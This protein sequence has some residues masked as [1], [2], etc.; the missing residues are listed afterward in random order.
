MRPSRLLAL[1]AVAALL[2]GGA[3][4]FMGKGKAPPPAAGG[5]GPVPVFVATAEKAAVPNRVR[6]VGTVK[7]SAV[8]AV[9]SRVDG[10]IVQVGFREGQDVKAGDLLFTIDQRPLQAQLRQ[11]EANLARDRAQ[12]SS[13]RHDVERYSELSRKDHVSRQQY[14]KAQATLGTL[15]A[16][17]K[18]DEAVIE[19]TKVQLGFTTIR[20]PI[21]GRVG[22]LLVDQGNLVKANDTGALV[23]IHRIKP[24]DVS[25]SVPERHLA[26][27]RARMGGAGL[28]VEVT[29]QDTEARPVTGRVSFIDNTVDA[30]TGTIGLKATFANEDLVLWPGQFVRVAM[31]LGG[32]EPTIAVPADALQ[33][34]QQGS[35]VYVVKP[36]QT[37]DLRV[38]K[39]ARIVDGRAAIAEGLAEGDRVVTE[40]HVRLAP[41]AKVAIREK[42]K[43]G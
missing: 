4:W 35:T 21:D 22:A 11:A 30:A 40:G 3:Y 28:P 5:P 6:S 32:E 25:F 17:I 19:A 20:S 16:T 34:G 7:A 2:G 29:T 15:E 8:V 33:E 41:G 26:D 9:K 31:P 13:A 14:E 10:E 27:I 23:V 39:V 43:A 1:V 42:A 24:V 12:L 38:V 36:D 18:A 37:V